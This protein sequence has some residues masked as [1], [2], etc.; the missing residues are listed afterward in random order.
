MIFYEP[1]NMCRPIRAQH[2]WYPRDSLILL[3]E[4]IHR[5]VPTPVSKNM[6]AL[7]SKLAFSAITDTSVSGFL[8][9]MFL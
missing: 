7:I 4:M 5:T 1:V 6:L 3:S 9:K 2:H 8:I